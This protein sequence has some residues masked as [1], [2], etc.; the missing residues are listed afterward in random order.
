MVTR[1]LKATRKKIGMSLEMP[2]WMPPKLLVL[3]CRRDL[4]MP[5]LWAA[6]SRAG[7]G[8][9]GSLCLLPFISAPRKPEPISKPLDSGDREHSVADEGLELVKGRL[10]EAGGGVRYRAAGAVVLVAQLGDAG[11]HALQGFGVRNSSTL[12]RVIVLARLGNVGS[13]LMA[14]VSPKSLIL[15][16]DVTKATISTPYMSLSPSLLRRRRPRGGWSRAHCFS[17]RRSWL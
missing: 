11:L 17:R 14:S 16:S 2:L 8:M 1:G 5:V 9:K 10:A 3:A 15:G 12:S 13:A 4:G 6:A 7:A